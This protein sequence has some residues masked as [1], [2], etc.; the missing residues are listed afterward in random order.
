MAVNKSFKVL[1]FKGLSP[2]SARWSRVVLDANI[3]RA[4]SSRTTPSAV[5]TFHLFEDFLH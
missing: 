4:I 3:G 1:N 5:E 2:A